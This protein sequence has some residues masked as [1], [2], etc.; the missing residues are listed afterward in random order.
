V[1]RTGTFCL[2]LWAGRGKAPLRSSR[3]GV[4]A[5]LEYNPGHYGE[6]ER[7]E[8]GW[9]ARLEQTRRAE[10]RICSRRKAAQGCCYAGGYIASASGAG[11]AARG[12]IA[13]SCGADSARRRLLDLRFAPW[14]GCRGRVLATRSLG[15]PR[16]SPRSYAD[17]T[18]H[19]MERAEGCF[20]RV[21]RGDVLEA[22]GLRLVE[23]VP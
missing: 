8:A 9:E 15:K 18:F 23:V 6:T 13:G 22:G 14:G 12:G 10:A 1:G 3:P 2:K 16:T 20:A 11:A 21:A 17:S 19:T 7:E 4:L 5:R